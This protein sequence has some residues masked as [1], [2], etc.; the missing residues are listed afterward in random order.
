M[1]AKLE[2]PEAFTRFKDALT[3]DPR[4]N[5]KVLRETDYFAEQS[6]MVSTLITTLGAVIALPD[7]HRRRVRRRQHDVLGGGR[8]ARARSP[9]CARSASAAGRWWCRC[10]PSRCC[11]RSSA[12]R[13][14]ARLAYVGFNGFQTSTINWQT[15]SQVAFAFAVTPGLIVAGIVYALLMGLLGGLLPAVRAAR[16]PSW[17][18]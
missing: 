5:L 14:A 10:W 18:H 7:G 15:F 11:W 12:A 3:T 17:R 1:Y 6:Q 9:R 4:L 8:R 13:S 2:S 16:L